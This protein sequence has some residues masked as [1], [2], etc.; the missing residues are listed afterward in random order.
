MKIQ[1]HIS[2]VNGAFFYEIS[3][4]SRLEETHALI[5]SLSKSEKRYFHR[6]AAMNA[7]AT[8][9]HYLD[10][11]SILADQVLFDEKK[12]KKEIALPGLRDNLPS[13]QHKL[14]RLVLKS[15][16][17]LES[18]RSVD[19]QLYAA[20]EEIGF[21]YRKNQLG[22]LRRRLSKN[23]KL[24]RKSG[25]FGLE[26]KL[27]EWERRL[28]LEHGSHLQPERLQ[29]IAGQERQSLKSQ[30]LRRTLRGLHDQAR[31]LGKGTL[32]LRSPR[33]RE[34]FAK[35]L[36]HPAL[37]SVP[38]DFLSRAYF[39]DIQAIY[40]IAQKD[41]AH[42]LKIYQ[43]LIDAWE[44]SPEF[45]ADHPDFYLGLLNN[46]ITV[47]F[48]QEL[49]LS[50]LRT[51][52]QLARSFKK[53]HKTSELKLVRVS[54]SLEL[55]LTMNLGSYEEGAK[56]ITEIDAWLQQNEKIL[57]VSR[58]IR[59]HY[60][61]TIFFFLNGNF[62]AAN[63]RLLTVLYMP[64]RAERTDIRDFARIFQLILQIELGNA[65]LNEYLSRS[66]F[67]YFRKTQRLFAFESRLIRFSTDF[68][69]SR[70]S[71]AKDKLFSDL[72]QD[73]EGMR[74]AENP[75]KD[76]TPL[77]L[78]ELIIWAES[79]IQGKGIGQLYKELVANNRKSTEK[80]S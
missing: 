59:F 67:R 1:R 13:I 75:S 21:L 56:L 40:A 71:H 6:F 48:L 68:L 80:K 2:F 29:E 44:H 58:V 52:L 65:D 46:Y 49:P 37:E 5:H 47:A 73:L 28:A 18:E 41:Q 25:R 7:G 32:A 36:E 23:L 63:Q 3:F 11:F 39:Y 77:G 12:I 74:K 38:G 19:S 27:L 76:P 10:L 4:L 70:D 61:I 69:D 60:N 42:A 72:K 43:P 14:Q 26:Q 51:K 64:G 22:I 53:L 31:S 54:L 24:A 8:G 30:D 33:D 57:P 15:M 55:L 34:A 9:S 62:K 50:I 45:I 20:L 78:E 79:H 66:A 16:R 17:V 35:I